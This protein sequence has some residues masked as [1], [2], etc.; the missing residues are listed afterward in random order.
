MWV[1][2]VALQVK[3]KPPKGHLPSGQYSG[4]IERTNADLLVIFDTSPYFT[5]QQYGSL[6]LTRAYTWVACS[7]CHL[8]CF[9]A[10][11][12]AKFWLFPHFQECGSLSTR[13]SATSKNRTGVLAMAIIWHP[14]SLRR[15]GMNKAR[16]CGD[17]KQRMPTNSFCKMRSCGV[18]HAW[19]LEL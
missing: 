6:I 3:L 7:W 5:I 19:C 9:A 15:M 2:A 8:R 14:R 13:D 11:R 1:K 18:L 17:H 16:L 12:L 10:Q 4:K